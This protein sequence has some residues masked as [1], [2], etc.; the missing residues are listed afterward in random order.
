MLFEVRFSIYDV[1]FKNMYKF[2]IAI[3]VNFFLVCNCRQV[4]FFSELG[5]LRS[6]NASYPSWS[7]VSVYYGGPQGTC[8][9]F[10]SC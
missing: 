8:C 3:L 9:K 5:R 1:R 4:L 2:E 10:K 7:L 6:F